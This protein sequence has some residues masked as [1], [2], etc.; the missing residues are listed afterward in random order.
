M[1]KILLWLLIA[2]MAYATKQSDWYTTGEEF[3]AS[4]TVTAQKLEDIVEKA[5]FKTG[6]GGVRTQA[7]SPDT[8]N[9]H[10]DS[11]DSYKLKYYNNSAWKTALTGTTYAPDYETGM[12]NKIDSCFLYRVD[13]DTLAVSAGVVTINGNMRRNTSSTT[14]DPTQ[15]DASDWSDVY[16]V[17]DNSG[18][19]FT[20]EVVDS[21]TAPGGSSPSGTNTRL[22]GSIFWDADQDLNKFINY[23]DDK[24]IGWNWLVGDDT[25]TI[26]ETIVFGVTFAS[27]PLVLACSEG[28][29]GTAAPV[30]VGDGATDSNAEI[31]HFRTITTTQGVLVRKMETGNTYSSSGWYLHVWVAHGRFS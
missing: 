21:S 15:L 27:T 6:K 3:T 13:D 2:S 11:D 30:D 28:S 25:Q 5:T 19:T 22:I 1:K 17:A 14:N 18:T 24:V 29:K 23:R 8:D 7:A 16:A 31:L 10:I 26:E 4:E 12:E 20:L 9:L